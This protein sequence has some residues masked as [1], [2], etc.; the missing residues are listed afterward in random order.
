MMTWRS[1]VLYSLLAAFI[2]VIYTIPISVLLGGWDQ[3]IDSCAANE[4]FGVPGASN[5]V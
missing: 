4:S 1:I 3:L 2:G 5:W